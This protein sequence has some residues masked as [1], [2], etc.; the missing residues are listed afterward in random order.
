MTWLFFIG[1]A[2]WAILVSV[3]ERRGFLALLLAAALLWPSVAT[4]Q[5]IIVNTLDCL[6][7][8]RA[9]L[10]YPPLRP[11]Y[12]LQRAAEWGAYQRS[13][14]GMNGHL[15][16]TMSGRR[17]PVVAGRWEGTAKRNSRRRGPAGEPWGPEDVYACYQNHRGARY[18]G[19][20]SVYNP[21]DGYWYYQINL[22]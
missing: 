7:V 18:A 9:V 2:V 19:V 20:A 22:Q 11:D 5:P 3:C 1:S 14:R 21:R 15:H 13:L 16:R 8:Q 6:N 4:S 10:G 17:S 12:R